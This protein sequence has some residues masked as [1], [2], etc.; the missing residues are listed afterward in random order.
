M[1][2]KLISMTEAKRKF[3][4]L[5]KEVEKGKSYIVTSRGKSVAL[6]TPIKPT[7]DHFVNLDARRSLLDRLRRQP[8]TRIGRWKRGDL[9]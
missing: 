4:G 2:T 5:L 1:A 9:Y 7:T 8:V 3:F 6:V